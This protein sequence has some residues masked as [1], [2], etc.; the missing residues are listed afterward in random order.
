MERML[1]GLLVL[2]LILGIMVVIAGLALLTQPQD[3]W[4]RAF[5]RRH[6]G[7]RRCVE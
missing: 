7:D 4:A 3:R 2:G 6:R 1:I 5:A